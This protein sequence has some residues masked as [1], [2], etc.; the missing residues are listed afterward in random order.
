L[1]KDREEPN[2]MYPEPCLY[3]TNYAGRVSLGQLGGP[4]RI[5]GQ[6]TLPED[7]VHC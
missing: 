6:P 2:V 7:S 3:V 4:N 5:Q 1:C